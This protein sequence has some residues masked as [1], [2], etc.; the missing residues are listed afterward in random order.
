MKKLASML[1]ILCASALAQ[2]AAPAADAQQATPPQ[3]FSSNIAERAAAPSYSDI[4][5]AGFVTREEFPKANHIVAGYQAPHAARFSEREL[6]YLEGS[7]Y[8][9]GTQYRVIR[10][11]RDPNQYEIFPGQNKL[12]RRS[13]DLF[14]DL[15]RVRVIRLEESIAVAMVEF[16]CEP[17]V[18]GDTV[19]PF[20]DRPNVVFAKRPSFEHF[21]PS[22]G[23]TGR[24]L[25][26]R[27]FD[28]FLGV[29][30]K[31]YINIGSDQGLK[32]GDYVRIS[33]NYDPKKMPPSDAV[34][35]DAPAR[36]DTQ[37]DAIKI[38]KRELRKLP[39]RGVGEAM[40]LNTTADTATVMVTSALED[41]NPGDVVEAAK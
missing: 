22:S 5:C 40:V 4:Q 38:G 41:I 17:M 33:R 10:K 23:S 11:Q 39:Y 25:M 3:M 26:G 30:Q 27:G 16:S 6:I 2:D 32:P 24:V 14:A 18:A 7:G 19:I 37:T 28:Q 29:T 15:G 36:E 21:M 9:V 31:L 1:L 13:G 8:S 35:L 34:S 20:V 12:L